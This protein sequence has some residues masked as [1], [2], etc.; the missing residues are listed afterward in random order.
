MTN[1]VQG[2]AKLMGRNSTDTLELLLFRIETL[3]RHSK[4]P[5]IGLEWIEIAETLNLRGAA[6][7]NADPVKVAGERID[8][9]I[10]VLERSGRGR[11]GFSG[12]Y[13]TTGSSFRALVHDPVNGGSKYLP[14]RPTAVQAAIDRYEW[15]MQHGIAY[16]NVGIFVE[17]YMKRNLGA[18]AEE[19]LIAALDFGDTQIKHPFARK[20]VEETLRRYRE[21]QGLPHIDVDRPVWDQIAALKRRVNEPKALIDVLPEGDA[22]ACSVCHELLNEHEPKAFIGDT[23]NIAH[24]RCIDHRGEPL[25][26]GDADPA[27]D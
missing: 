25:Q 14:S 22:S 19:A 6:P 9:D 2:A 26:I 10:S 16:G 8:F 7:A 5:E 21:K 27:I 24:A 18:T 12:V 17:D 20:Q 1:L 3:L 15:Y 11:T 4:I 13:A 23:M